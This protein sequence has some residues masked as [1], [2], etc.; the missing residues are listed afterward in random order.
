MRLVE[1]LVVSIGHLPRGRNNLGA[2]NADLD[3]L[4]EIV[5]HVSQEKQS[6]GWWKTYVLSVAANGGLRALAAEFCVGSVP[7]CQEGILS[8]RGEVGG[9]A[10][11]RHSR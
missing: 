6:S 8:E 2:A 7:S 9:V 5:S 11:E 1:R 4:S 3:T 10:Y